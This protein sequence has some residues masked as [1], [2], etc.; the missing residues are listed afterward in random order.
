LRWP[1]L[2][3]LKEAVTVVFSPRFTTRFPAEPHVAPEGY[4]GKPEFDLDNCIGCGA[5]VNVCPTHGACLSMEE[6]LSANPPVRKIRLHYSACIFCGNCSDKCTTEKGI[7]LTNEWDLATLDRDETTE[8]HDFELQLCEKCSAVIGT[9]KHLLW[10]ADKLGPIAYANPS[11]LLSKSN[12]I[13]S[14]HIDKLEEQLKSPGAPDF[15]RILCPECKSELNIR[16]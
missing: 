12:D 15:M 8:I 16:L 5:C 1:K 2:R 11:L 9:K 14:E 4:R 10:L 3:E 7:N 13:H 6:D